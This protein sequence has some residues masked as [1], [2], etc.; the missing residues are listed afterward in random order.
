MEGW[1]RPLRLPLQTP[2][3]W[4]RTWQDWEDHQMERK[5]RARCGCHTNHRGETW[6]DEVMQWLAKRIAKGDWEK[7]KRD[8][9]LEP[10][11]HVKQELLV[12]EGFIFRE[13]QIV[14]PPVLQRKVVKLWHSLAHLGKTKTKQMLREKYWFP[15]MNSMTD[16]AIDQC[17]ECRVAV[18]GNREEPIKVTS[19]PNRHSIHRQWWTVPRWTP[20]SHP[21]W[22]ENQIPSGI[23]CTIDRLPDQQGEIEAHLCHMWNSE[24]NWERHLTPIQF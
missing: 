13:C 10:Y 15:L 24:E 5:C 8:K 11:L 14:L 2:S 6:K 19:I 22:Q 4:D 21:D 23:V 16:T 12:A 17:Y 9:D 7:H 20:Q 18:K 1:S 3:A